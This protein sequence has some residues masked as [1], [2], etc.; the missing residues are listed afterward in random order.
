[1]VIQ[2]TKVEIER[3]GRGSQAHPLK[4]KEEHYPITEKGTGDYSLFWLNAWVALGLTI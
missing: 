3:Q 2:I 1:M 4:R